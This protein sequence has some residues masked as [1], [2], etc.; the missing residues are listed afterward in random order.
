MRFKPV[1]RLG[2]SALALGKKI[3][4]TNE[5]AHQFSFVDRSNVMIVDKKKPVIDA[6]FIRQPASPIK[7][8]DF[9]ALELSHWVRILT[10]EVNC[11][12][13]RI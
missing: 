1:C 2:L 12:S 8:G 4:T 11:L 3:I 5:W 6:D 10:G 7:C 9:D 13:F